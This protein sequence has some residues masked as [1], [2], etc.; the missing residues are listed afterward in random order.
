MKVA[1]TGS[2]GIADPR[3]LQLAINGSK[4]DITEIAHGGSPIGAD[5][6]AKMWAE[7][8]GIPA[9]SFYIRRRE[10][11]KHGPSIRGNMLEEFGAEA[12]IALW[13]CKSEATKC[14]IDRARELGIPV[15]VLY[16]Y[17]DATGA[18]LC[19]ELPP[20]SLQ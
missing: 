10:W 19:S 2:R 13:D 12:L 5:F 9:T 8:N 17:F 15:H 11:Q 7:L 3:I 16:V 20:S 18:L 14:C 6:L 1:I 4:F